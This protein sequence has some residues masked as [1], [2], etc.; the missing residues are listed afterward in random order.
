MQQQESKTWL[1][2]IRNEAKHKT[3]TFTSTSTSRPSSTSTST[4]AF[5]STSK[6]DIPRL[7]PW[8]FIPRGRYNAVAGRWSSVDSWLFVYLATL[9][10]LQ[11][12]I[13]LPHA[14]LNLY[15]GPICSLLLS[16]VVALGFPFQVGCPLAFDLV[17]CSGNLDL[18]SPSARNGIRSPCS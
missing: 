6:S 13:R 10:G 9:L 4:S 12:E 7:W 5:T 16:A 3:F 11:V 14:A 1:T 15:L 18:W 2:A 17:H 8:Q